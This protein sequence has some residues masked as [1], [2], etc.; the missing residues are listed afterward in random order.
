[1]NRLV[2]EIGNAAK[3]TDLTFQYKP[4]DPK[5]KTDKTTIPFQVELLVYSFKLR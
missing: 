1:M 5:K 4:K 3:K 2:K